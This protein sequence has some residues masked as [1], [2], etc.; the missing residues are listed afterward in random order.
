MTNIASS[1]AKYFAV[2]KSTCAYASRANSACDLR[3]A[4]FDRQRYPCIFLRVFNASC[5]LTLSAPRLHKSRHCGAHAQQKL[6]VS[7]ASLEAS[8]CSTFSTYRS[9]RFRRVLS[10]RLDLSTKNH[11]ESYGISARPRKTWT[12]RNRVCRK[13]TTARRNRVCRKCTT[14]GS[15]TFATFPQLPLVWNTH[16]QCCCRRLQN[17]V[18]INHQLSI[19]L[20][21][22]VIIVAIK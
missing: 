21:F 11:V 17:A 18:G 15:Q 3:N 9:T 7:R 19:V 1:P 8:F 22:S 6:Q 5:G 12:R 20:S 4:Q 10:V 2:A 13:C 16:T 14:D